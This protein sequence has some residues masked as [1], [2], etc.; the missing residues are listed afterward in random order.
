MSEKTWY[1]VLLR[2]LWYTSVVLGALA[3][4]GYVTMR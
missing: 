1:R 3:L 4:I 2:A